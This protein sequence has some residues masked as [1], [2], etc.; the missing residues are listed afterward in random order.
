VAPSLVGSPSVLGSAGLAARI[1]LNG[2]EGQMMMPP[3]ALSDEQTAAV[4]TY[5][6]RAWGNGASP[7][8]PELVREARGASTGRTR[9]WTDEELKQ[10]TQPDGWPAK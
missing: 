9:P 4:L 3:V 10:V 6:R 2:K 5:V 1:V 7:V 8:S